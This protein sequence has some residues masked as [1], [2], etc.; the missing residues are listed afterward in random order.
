RG[1]AVDQRRIKRADAPVAAK[2]QAIAMRAA[3]RQRLLDD[4]GTLLTGAGQCHPDRVKD[5]RLGPFDG[6]LWQIVVA[7]R[8]DLLG[9]L[10]DQGHGGGPRYCLLQLRRSAPSPGAKRT[11]SGSGMLWPPRRRS[12]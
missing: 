8:D 9:N 2:D 4:P 5:R 6:L 1:S 11:S 7:N 12:S 10:F 3:H